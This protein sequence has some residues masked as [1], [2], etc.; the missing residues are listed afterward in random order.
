MQTLLFQPYH[1]YVY[2]YFFEQF[3]PNNTVENNTALKILR[4]VI[5]ILLIVKL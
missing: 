3:D 1:M 4:S 5:S 2:K